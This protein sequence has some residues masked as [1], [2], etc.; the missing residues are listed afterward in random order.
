MEES[1]CQKATGSLQTRIKKDTGGGLEFK[2][3]FIYISGHCYLSI[4]NRISDRQRIHYSSR[5]EN[6]MTKKEAQKVCAK[7]EHSIK[8]ILFNGLVGCKFNR[9][10]NVDGTYTCP[11][12]LHEE[13]DIMECGTL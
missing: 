1:V 10:A 6:F 2:K 3:H 13:R 5:K 11:I 9:K 8:N 7:C 4:Y 12:S